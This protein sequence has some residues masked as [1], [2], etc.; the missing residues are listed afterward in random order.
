MSSCLKTRQRVPLGANMAVRSLIERVGGFDP[1]LGR[2]GNVFRPEQAEFFCRSRATGA[3]S[4][5]EIHSASRPGSEA[6][7]RY[8]ALVVLTC[9]VRASTNSIR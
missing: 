5:P 7:A 9:P 1:Q 4:A 3:G 6:Y 8:Q 2:R